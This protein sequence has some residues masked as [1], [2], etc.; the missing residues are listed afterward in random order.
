MIIT[1]AMFFLCSAVLVMGTNVRK[2]AVF[3]VNQDKAYY[4]AEAGIEKVLADAKNGP[5]WLMNLN[6]G[7]EYDFLANILNG[8]KN[9]GEGTFEYIRVKKL[10]EDNAQTT[11]EIE[12]RGKCGGS[13]KKIKVSAVLDTVYAAN[14]F[15]GLW[16]VN[17]SA[18]GGHVFN[19]TG[20]AYFSGGDIVIV[21]GSDITGDIYSR[22]K[23]FLQC[24]GGRVTEIHG[25]IYTLGGVG[26]TGSGP[27]SFD[28]F[29]YVDDINKVPEAVKNITIVLPAGE[30][31][32]KIP[33]ISEFPDLLDA[34]RLAWYQK[35]AGYNQLPT[36]VNDTMVFQNGIY[37]LTGDYELSGSYSGNALIV[38][39]GSVTL[40]SLI[41]SGGSD[42]LAVLSAGSIST[43][44]DSGE[45][46]A[47]VYSSNQVNFNSGTL[48]KGSVL[49]ADL[50][51][52]GS[53]ISIS[54]DDEMVNAFR[55]VSSWT[56]CFVRIT[57]WNG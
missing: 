8:Q 3:E 7:S 54:Y 24:E 40:G 2:I 29:I 9:Y 46:D 35:N 18:P 19:L 31:A 52:Q 17:G 57:K 11:L 39:D 26:L 20:D 25:N 51:G 12:S 38:I 6:V 41:R 32:A 47:L 43:N 14:L 16:V 34:D 37:F 28:G 22:D 10:A 27:L 5:S 56:T 15:R 4:T 21:S 33:G 50:A 23:V 53:R 45:I 30:L 13:I 1:L 42:S 44:L 49:A 36:V 55:D 48:V